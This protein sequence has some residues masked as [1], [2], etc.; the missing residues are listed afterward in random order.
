MLAQ[1]TMLRHW[2]SE[3]NEETCEDACGENTAQGLFAVADGVGT[4][5]FS[6]A[7][8]NFLVQHFLHVPLLSND[9]FE[10]EWWVRLFQEQFKNEFSAGA[11]MAWNAQQKAQSQG[12]YS[13]LATLRVLESDAIHAEVSLL[14]FGDSCVFV[15]KLSA[16]HILSFPLEQADEFERAPI[17]IPSKPGVFNRYFH[18]CH[19]A[20]LDLA[21]ADI[22]V[23]ATD[24]VSKWIVSAGSGRYSDKKKAFQ[25]VIQ[26]TT[27][28]WANFIQECRE[29]KEMVDDDCTALIIA[30]YPDTASHGLPLGTTTGH[31]QQVRESRKQEFIQAL[32]EQNK[33]RTAIC[34][35]DGRDLLAES[36]QVSQSDILLARKVADAQREVLAI[37]RQEINNPNV[38]A[39]MAP[40]WQ[41]HVHLLYQER[42]AENIRKTLSRLGIPI[43][44]GAPLAS[45][46]PA[47]I[48]SHPSMYDT[49]MLY[50][51]VFDV[52]EIQQAV[53]SSGQGEK[54]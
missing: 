50:T 13:T 26:Q 41:K 18:Q 22:V 44:P 52:T 37:L 17:C 6:D 23:I 16:E 43:A 34:F 32:K 7:W 38:V 46:E 1:V 2:K 35:G 29:R 25:E 27:D 10:V 40:V 51:Q 21:S 47:E 53:Q 24:A 36:V 31:S 20:S 15:S 54:T 45:Q 19:I 28:S 8:A 33:E 14:A 42:C 12:S 48:A 11:N 9:P 49:D 5:L 30:L 39:I 4:T 3:H